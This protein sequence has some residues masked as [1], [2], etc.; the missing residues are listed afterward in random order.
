MRTII[1]VL[2][3]CAICFLK[4]MLFSGNTKF[5]KAAYMWMSKQPVSVAFVF[6]FSPAV[7]VLLCGITVLVFPVIGQG[8]LTKNVVFLGIIAL[9]ILL[10]TVGFAAKRVQQFRKLQ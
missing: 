8:F 5:D 1:P 9:M 7:S 2:S 3:G 4:Y 6:Q 10:D